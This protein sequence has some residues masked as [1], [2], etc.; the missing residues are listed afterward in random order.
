MKYL[1]LLL[2]TTSCAIVVPVHRRK[3]YVEE[4]TYYYRENPGITTLKKDD[5]CDCPE[6]YDS[7][8]NNRNHDRRYYR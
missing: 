6:D 1:I 3:V 7:Y 8:H 5:Y 2:L 4:P